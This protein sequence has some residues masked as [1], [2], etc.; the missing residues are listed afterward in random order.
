[1][2]DQGTSSSGP[3]A[4]Q[5]YTAATAGPMIDAGSQVVLVVS[6]GVSSEPAGPPVVVPGIVGVVQGDALTMLQEAG[7][8]AQVF[9]THSG[10]VRKGRVIGQLPEANLR[11]SPGTTALLLVS[12]GPSPSPVP[13]VVFPDVIGAGE[14]DAA[15]RLRAAGLSPQVVRQYS[16]TVPAGIVMATLPN[17]HTLAPQ[18][19][20]TS[21]WVWVAAALALLLLAGGVWFFARQSTPGTEVA[22]VATQTAEATSAAAP[23]EESSAAAVPDVVGMPKDDA[24]AV[25]VDAGFVPVAK[26]EETEDADAGDVTAQL[27]AAGSELTRGSQVAIQIAKAPEKTKPDT[28]KVPNVVGMTQSEAQS[29]LAKVDLV[30]SFV[31]QANDAPKGE[32]FSQQPAS[33]ESVAPNSVILV[34]ISTGP[35]VDPE[36][37]T[38]AVPVLIGETQADA[39]S[40]LAAAQLSAQVV[41]SYSSTVEAGIVAQQWPP[42]GNRVAPGTPVALVV[43]MGP[44]P[45]DGTATV[46][47]VKGMDAE[48]A[49]QALADAGL[50]AQAVNIDDPQAKPDVV[51]GQ[52]PAASSTVPTGSTVLIGIAGSAATPY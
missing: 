25:L 22:E 28:V 6:Q 52:L 12:N 39:E 24:E 36:P 47:D 27:P 50:V 34:A 18:S 11:A 10:V 30:S 32:A 26:Y 5:V 21:P 29:A 51:L 49:T 8:A 42:A 9:N 45:A 48:S 20:R 33:G 38:V 13:Q 23:A 3:T 41:Q 31:Q 37:T 46:P 35:A 40:A 14:G 19:K 44:K 43:S 16:D 2:S 4:G 15:E 7:L 17:A 1:M